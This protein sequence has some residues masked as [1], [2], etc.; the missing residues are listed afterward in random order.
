[1]FK[2]RKK[3]NEPHNLLEK[4]NSQGMTRMKWAFGMEG[5]QCCETLLIIGPPV[6]CTP[7]IWV[8]S[9]ITVPL[10]QPMIAIINI[11]KL[12][13]SWGYTMANWFS[14]TTIPTWL[15]WGQPA[16]GRTCSFP[17]HRR[18]CDL[19]WD[20][21]YKRLVSN[22]LIFRS[23]WEWQGTLIIVSA[24]PLTSF[25]NFNTCMPCSLRFQHTNT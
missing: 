11:W 1:M 13:G 10:N 25:Q 15:P 21:C 7:A 20:C 16:T 12:P 22:L 14:S 23:G 8:C 24:L 6:S 18:T 5:N 3:A 4:P 17:I 19:A 9:R 2:S